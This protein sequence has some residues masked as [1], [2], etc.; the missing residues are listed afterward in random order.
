MTW[1]AL[2]GHHVRIKGSTK[3]TALK[4]SPAP[5]SSGAGPGAFMAR[6]D[7]GDHQHEHGS[8]PRTA[9]HPQHIDSLYSTDGTR[10][11]R[12]RFPDTNGPP[13]TPSAQCTQAPEVP[14]AEGCCDAACGMP[15]TGLPPFSASGWLP[16]APKFLPAW[17]AQVEPLQSQNATLPMRAWGADPF[18]KSPSEWR[19]KSPCV[20]SLRDAPPLYK[21]KV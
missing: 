19:I 5:A 14:S 10:L 12:A 16:N 17:K 4:W 1:S 21:S 6:I 18:R 7:G 8:S 3:L 11:T 20:T 2:P 13:D 9:Q 15:G